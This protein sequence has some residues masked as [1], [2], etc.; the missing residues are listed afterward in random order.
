VPPSIIGLSSDPLAPVMVD[1]DH[2]DR[3]LASPEEQ[4]GRQ[5][6]VPHGP[7]QPE[8]TAQ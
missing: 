2:G 4:F 5:R 1:E 3:G 7:P 6:V 8:L